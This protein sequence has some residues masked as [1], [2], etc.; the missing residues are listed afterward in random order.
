[1]STKYLQPAVSGLDVSPMLHFCQFIVILMSYSFDWSGLS[2]PR[3]QNPRTN[4]LC[5]AVSG[6]AMNGSLFF[7][8][9]NYKKLFI[10]YI[11][12]EQ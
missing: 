6:W 8:F 11:F 3:K 1:M 9:S 7:F 5:G 10:Q 4:D 2:T 12:I